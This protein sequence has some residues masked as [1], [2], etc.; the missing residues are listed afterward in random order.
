MSVRVPMTAAQ[1]AV[2]PMASAQ[3]IA[4]VPLTEWLDVT[5]FTDVYIPMLN[6]DG[7]GDTVTFHV[8]MAEDPAHP[9][10]N[11]PAFTLAPGEADAFIER[12][13][14]FRYLRLSAESTST[15]PVDV[16]FGVYG[17]GNDRGVSEGT[18]KL[19]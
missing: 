9:F 12:G 8:E 13:K 2:V 11:R 10:V 14:F 7:E 19:G 3:V 15:D 18:W 17:K 4:L 6:V 1:V 5:A 16:K